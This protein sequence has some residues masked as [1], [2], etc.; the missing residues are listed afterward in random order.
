[1][2]QDENTLALEKQSQEILTLAS[3]YTIANVEQ[4]QFAGEELKNIKK[5]VKAAETMRK[6]ATGPLDEAKKAI[7]AW[8]KPIEERYALAETKIKTAMLTYQKEEEKKRLAAEAKAA[9][10][11][12]KEQARLDA[13]AM[14]AA[15]RALEDHDTQK[16]EAII[17]AVPVVRAAPV[18]VAAPRITGI[19]TREVWKFRVIDAKLVP[20]EYKTVNETML[21]QVARSTKGKLSV[22]GVEFYSEETMSASSK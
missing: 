4:F 1:M 18:P 2:I 19:S 21:G 12:R 3:V 8:F 22:P 10:E 14:A 20:E 9:E 15:E 5:G 17:N 6:E 7:M 11:A 13:L 16:A